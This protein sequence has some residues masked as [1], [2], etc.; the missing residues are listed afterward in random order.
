[1]NSE[2]AKSYNAVGRN[3]PEAAGTNHDLH[4]VKLE[5]SK[6]KIVDM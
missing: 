6:Y 1:M 3:F 5:S 2:E 4:D